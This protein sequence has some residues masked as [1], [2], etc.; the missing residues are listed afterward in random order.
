MFKYGIDIGNAAVKC[1]LLKE[2]KQLS[3]SIH[4]SAVS[5]IID[6]KYIMYNEDTFY[7]QVVDSPLNHSDKIVAFGQEALNLPNYKEFDVESTSYKANNELTTTLLFGTL[8]KEVLT[9]TGKIPKELT[10]TLAASVPIVEAKTLKLVTQ[11]EELLQNTHIINVYLPTGI[12]QV[13]V[14]ISKVKVYNE[15]QA[16]FLGLLDTNDDNFQNRMMTIYQE[17]GESENPISTLEDFLIVD[18]G[19]GTTD[20]AVFRNKKFNPEFSY[21]VTKGY[22]N[23]LEEAMDNARREGITVESR[24]DLQE[25]LTSNNKRR[26]KRKEMWESYVFPTKDAYEKVLLDTILKTYGNR[27]FFDAIIFLGG[28]FS[29]L[30]HFGEDSKLEDIQLFDKLKQL[31]DDNHKTVDLL[32]GVP[33]PYSRTINERGLKQVLTIM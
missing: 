4:P 22:G 19:E 26:L 17:L 14:T 12:K 21:S 24:K 29:A 30:T 7:I 28:G 20:L 9:A 3:E 27:D 11:Y 5:E 15:G 2:N 13:K 33:A 8:I 31:L 16:G 10:I 23:L 18:I 1:V 6:E 32:F 25:T